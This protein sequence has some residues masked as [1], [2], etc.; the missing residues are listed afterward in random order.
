MTEL[1]RDLYDLM[2]DRYG[3]DLLHRSDY[4]ACQE[5][6]RSLFAKLQAALGEE[7][8]EKVN[9]ITTEMAQMELETA[10]TWGLRLGLALPDL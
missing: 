7:F 9:D 5:V 1:I 2:E 10:F 6:Q 8:C 4:Q 3:Q